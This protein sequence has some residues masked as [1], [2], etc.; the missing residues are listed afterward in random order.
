MIDK[1]IKRRKTLEKR[2]YE[3]IKR[4]IETICIYLTSV[5]IFQRSLTLHSHNISLLHSL[6]VIFLFDS[7]PNVVCDSTILDNDFF[8][9]SF[10]DF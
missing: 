4:Q 7:F 8:S 1:S 3:E 6:F 2:N 9:R 10:N 5:N